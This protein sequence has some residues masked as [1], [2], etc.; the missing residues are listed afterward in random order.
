M[1]SPALS[2]LLH[3]ALLLLLPAAAH[4][5]LSSEATFGA[6]FDVSL[7]AIVGVYN[8]ISTPPVRAAGSAYEKDTLAG[9]CGSSSNSPW[10]ALF[11]GTHEELSLAAYFETKVGGLVARTAFK[12]WAQAT[13]NAWV[14]AYAPSGC[15]LSTMRENMLMLNLAFVQFRNTQSSSAE[16]ELNW[17]SALTPQEWDLWNRASIPPTPP[18]ASPT[19]PPPTPAPTPMPATLDWRTRGAITAVVNQG[20]CGSCYSFA[21]NDA[22]AARVVTATGGPLVQLSQQSVV[23]CGINDAGYGCNGG[24]PTRT[25]SW[26]AEVGGMA[27]SSSYPYAAATA[28]GS[29]NGTCDATKRNQAVVD[30][31]GS[32]RYAERGTANFKK[33][34]A[35][36]PQSIVITSSCS[37]FMQYK[38]G[39]LTDGDVSWLRLQ[40]PRRAGHWLRH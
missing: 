23:S 40:E 2:L 39:I 20:Q 8:P 1:R 35:E 30:T 36:T 7:T 13:I 38:S 21:A 17:L 28:S 6:N 3:V 25:W 27:G 9:I 15:S 34:I 5:G 14:A 18:T 31:S 24:W 10:G 33:A 19:N 32:V 26:A 29:T 37:G 4:A 11:N 22:L 12:A 16:F